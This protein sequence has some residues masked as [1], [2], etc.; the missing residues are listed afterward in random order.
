VSVGFGMRYLLFL[1]FIFPLSQVFSE[2][3]S[4]WG[5][6]NAS[7]AQYNLFKNRPEINDAHLSW[8]MGFITGYN[9]NASKVEA[10]FVDAYV[11]K[12]KLDMLCEDHPEIKISFAASVIVEK[13]KKGE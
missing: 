7:C 13:S 5:Y 6:G 8:V 4:S 1:L 10:R 3:H 12:N 2:G 9:Y 11:I